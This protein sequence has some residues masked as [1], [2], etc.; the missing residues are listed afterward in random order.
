M[1]L[2][3]RSHVSIVGQ[4]KMRMINLCEGNAEKE[5]LK[6]G[7]AWQSASPWVCMS[8]VMPFTPGDK[9]KE[10]STYNIKLTS[11]S[12]QSSDSEFKL[13]GSCFIR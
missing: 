6:P 11:I 10:A 3:T 2:Q 12:V 8:I 5:Q 13:H 4:T 9:S 1:I 7:G